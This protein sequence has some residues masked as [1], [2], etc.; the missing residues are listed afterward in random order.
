MKTFLSLVLFATATAF[1]ASELTVVDEAE[2]ETMPPKQAALLKSVGV[3][4]SI[5]VSKRAFQRDDRKIGALLTITQ[6][7]DKNPPSVATHI[8]FYIDENN[9]LEID[10]ANPQIFF[11]RFVSEV[12]VSATNDSITVT[13]PKQKYCEVFF[14]STRKFMDG[15]EHER[16]AS[17]LL[18]GDG[19][20][21]AR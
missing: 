13:A 4:S 12:Q 9:W 19:V 21:I 2:K 8:Q 10:L 16:F 1:G 17:S 18:S 3:N 6:A 11:S 5:K 14:K 15:A 20:M 7:V